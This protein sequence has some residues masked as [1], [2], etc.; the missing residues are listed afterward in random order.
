MVGPSSLGRGTLKGH[1]RGSSIACM[2]NTGIEMLPSDFRQLAFLL[3]L[4]HPEIHVMEQFQG[5]QR[6]GQ[7]ELLKD[8]V[9]ERHCI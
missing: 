3:Y 8:Q 5:R 7:S 6:Y 9:P 2:I 1:I 4:L